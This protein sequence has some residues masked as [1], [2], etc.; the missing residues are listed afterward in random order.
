MATGTGKV[1]NLA[2]VGQGGVGKTML[3]EAMLHLTGKT[4]RLGGHAGTKPTLDYD[5]EEGAR[6]FS[7][8]TTIAPVEYGGCRINVLDAPC[9]PDFVGDAYGALAA[10]ETALFVIDAAAGPGAITTRLWYAAE[11][12]SL[13]RA[14]FINR[15]DRPDAD[16]DTALLAAQE[17][18][19]NR[20]AAVT[21]PMGS[22]EAFSGVVDVVHQKAR[23]L[24][25]GKVE[26]TNVPAEYADAARQ[27]HDQ[28]VELV[29]EADDDLMMKYL[30]GQPIT[31]EELEGL[32]AQA[33]MQRVFV[34]VFAGSCVREEGVISLLEDVAEWFPTMADYGRVPLVNGEELEISPD[35]DRPVAFVFKSLQDQQNGKLSFI[36]VLAGTITPGTELTCAR[37]RKTERLGHLYRMTGR[38]TVDL[39]Q[40]AAGDV[41]VVPKLEALT[42]DTLSVTGK[43]EAAAFRFPNSL[44]RVAIEPDERGSEGKVYAFLERSAEADPTLSVARDEDTGQTVVSAI[45]EAQVSVLLDRLEERTG[46]SAHT[47]RLRIPYRETIRRV[48]SAQGRHKKQTGGAGQ[49]GDCW[50]R[51]EPNPGAGYEFVDEVVGGHVP[52]NFIPAIDKGVQETMADGVLAGYPMIDVKVAVYDGSYHPVDSN[53]MAFKTAAR[54]GFQKAVAQAEPV[55]LEPM[56]HLSITV[57]DSYA[58]SVM[59]DVSASRGRIEGMNAASDKG[60]LA[61][62]TTIEATIPYAEVTDYATR[63]RSLSRGTGEFT[64]E[65]SGYEQVPHDVQERLAAEYEQK[66]AGGR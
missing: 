12:F 11:D 22:G 19:G 6:G 31:P 60:A 66:R 45:G 52:R 15:L 9:Y 25:D 56:A 4:S 2:L 64:L 35:D 23:T 26:T 39:K 62:S 32:L 38:E 51:V 36:K 18:Y 59:G 49:Y 24:R 61:G 30:D 28:L 14:L 65:L 40:V 33:L 10:A 5:A 29:V 3:A 43:V 63:L 41:C 50:L 54:I 48:A 57:P 13:A 44:Y 16:W 27:A 42:G 8:S 1:K 47:V 21:I 17:R 37:T 7:I 55:L 53:E 20:L 58:G 46:T 34:P